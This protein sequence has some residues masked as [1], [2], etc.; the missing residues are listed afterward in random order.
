MPCTFHMKQT[1]LVI[2]CCAAMISLAGCSSGNGNATTGTIAG[3]SG[4]TSSGG[5]SGSSSGS[6]GDGSGG[7]GYYGKGP[8]PPAGGP[9]KPLKVGCN[10]FRIYDYAANPNQG[11]TAF[12]DTSGAY[13]AALG[14]THPS[15]DESLQIS[16]RYP[17]V[18]YFSLQVYDQNVQIKDELI[19]Y[20]IQPDPGASNPFTAPT[21]IDPSISSGGNYTAR[22]LFEAPLKQSFPNTMYRGKVSALATNPS[23][24]NLLYRTYLPTSGT[25]DPT[26][27]VDLPKLVLH[28]NN[29]DIPLSA[30]PDA[31]DCRQLAADFLA[32]STKAQTTSFILPS[33]PPKFAAYKGR[34]GGVLGQGT[35]KN[36]DIGYLYARTTLNDGNIV[37]IRGRAPTFA[38]EGNGV[39]V[40]NVRYWSI[41]ENNYKSQAVVSC[42]AD[43]DAAIGADGFYNI[44]VST[45]DARPDNADR[46]HGFSWIAWGPQSD[47]ILIYR[48]LLAASTYSQA[49]ENVT[50]LNVLNPSANMGDY[51]PVATYC[52][53]A[54]F[55]AA[56]GETPAKVFAACQ[57]ASSG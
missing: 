39:S 1:L 48:Q 20:L 7:T 18:R 50:L 54:T 29:G 42:V 25:S 46:A 49:I 17:G 33:N 53:K 28:T 51:D 22:L 2:A 14:P 23:T 36:A 3:S 24:T 55:E 19:D 9:T 56:A 10:W 32:Q 41:C 27:G 4:G 15:S 35:A 16:G 8:L 52:P 21:V 40:P 6:G 11:N 12:P 30:S 37:L 13:W 44:V 5:S 26:G 47:S 38:Q 34:L 57:A 43:R 45:H 31:D